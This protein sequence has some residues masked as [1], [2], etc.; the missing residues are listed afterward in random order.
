MRAA[1]ELYVRAG[2]P[3][4]GRLARTPGGDV[5]D[6]LGPSIRGFWK[7]CPLERLLGLWREAR[8]ERVRTRTLSLRGGV[9]VWGGRGGWGRDRNVEISP[10][11]P[12]TS[13]SS[14]DSTEGA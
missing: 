4:L 9:V 3:L 5:G 11:V 12:T 13:S 10:G 14:S 6:F 2:P 1:W 8:V 7:R